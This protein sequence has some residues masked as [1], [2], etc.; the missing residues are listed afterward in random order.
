MVRN[1]WIV[2]IV[3]ESQLGRD[4]TVQK[5]TE[6]GYPVRC[7]LDVRAR[8]RCTT[9]RTTA[10]R[11]K[12]TVIRRTEIGNNNPK[13]RQP[14][15]NSVEQSVASEKAKWDNKCLRIHCI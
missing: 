12:I 11:K 7:E 9:D 1:A 3:L 5:S 13:Q 6:R 10:K 8:E 14:N 4:T 2:G 15:I